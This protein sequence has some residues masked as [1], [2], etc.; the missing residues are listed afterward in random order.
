MDITYPKA[1]ALRYNKCFFP[2]MKGNGPFSWSFLFIFLLFSFLNTLSFIK[3][4][5]P[6]A[7]TEGCDRGLYLV[8]P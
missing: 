3:N 6:E 4:K 7:F 2:S 8:F 1:W 5:V